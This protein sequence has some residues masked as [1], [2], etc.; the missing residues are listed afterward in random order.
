M[1]LVRARRPALLAAFAGALLALPALPAAAAPH[2]WTGAVNGNWSNPG[3]WQ[4]SSAP[5]AGEANVILTFPSGMGNMGTMV[6][7][8]AGLNVVGMSFYDGA[9]AVTGLPINLAGTVAVYTSSNPVDLDVDLVLTG[10]T[11]F[12][13]GSCQLNLGG[14]I[15]GAFGMT[16]QG[17]SGGSV[18]ISGGNTYTG[19]TT[20]ASGQLHLRSN[21]ALGSAAAGTVLLSFGELWLEGAV[22]SG[23]PLLSQG[24]ATPTIKTY[25]PVGLDAW[26]GPITLVAGNT[27]IGSSAG[28]PLT[29]GGSIDGSGGLTFQLQDAAILSGDNTYTGA[30]RI[31]SGTVFVNGN[32]PSSAWLIG[33]QFPSGSFLRGSGTVGP[34]SIDSSFGLNAGMKFVDPGASGTAV[35]S[36]GSIDLTDPSLLSGIAIHIGGTTPGSGHDQLAVTGTVTVT[37]SS[38]VPVFSYTPGAVDSFVV[39]SNDGSDA[40]VGTFGGLPEGA[41]FSAGGQTLSIT[42]AGGDGN[43]IVLTVVPPPATATVSGSASICAGNST[44]IQA[45]LTGTAPWNVTWSDAVVQNGVMASPATRSV[46]P[47]ST[48]TYTVT[49]ISDAN[50]PGTASGSAVV[51]VTSDAGPPVVTPPSPLTLDQTL[52]CGTFGGVTPGDSAALGAFVDGG[53]ATDD[54]TASPLRLTARIGAVDVTAATC[55]E[56]GPTSVTFRFEDAAGQIG[57]ADAAVTVRMYGDLNLDAVVD[58]SDYVILRDYL[59]FV[60]T[61]G[62]PPFA[63][64]LAL[65]DLTHDATVD[66]GDF[67]VIRDYLNFV[68]PCLAP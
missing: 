8:V 39:V 27:T 21:T 30:S 13:A 6:N 54:C 32:Q 33:A 59:N 58:P 34:V 37:N 31:V 61:P 10:P 46:S 20:V 45:A 50:G 25:A 47:P 65:A 67:V 60:M 2:T 28:L 16:T 11:T 53:S 49:A 40:V 18:T 24:P 44:T 36:T 14:S 48:L 7:D 23:E 43:D 55:F 63:A 62:V 3:N 35:L 38:I 15:S 56:A 22:V 52:C 68:T 1:L 57:T 29:L 42:Y 4:L 41:S 26:N 17:G 51:T 12:N 19:T 9:Y 5:G 64:P 66:P